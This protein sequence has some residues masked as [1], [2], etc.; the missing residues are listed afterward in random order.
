LKWLLNERAA[1]AGRVATLN[2]STGLLKEQV[3]CA[4]RRVDFLAG[5]VSDAEDRLRDADGSLHALDVVLETSF[6]T[7][8]QI[9]GGV[10][11]AWAGKY[12]QRGGL[13][14]HILS[15]LRKAAPGIVPTGL[16][17]KVAISHFGLQLT[18]DKE[19]VAF[20]RQ[21]RNILRGEPKLVEEL[22]K[23][24]LRG[25]VGWRWRAAPSLTELLGQDDWHEATD[26]LRPEVGG[27]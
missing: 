5:K 26:P 6:P 17:A 14:A 16:L 19:K 13:K 25:A 12:G 18:S 20:R 3:L 23:Q 11:R 22:G 27:Q 1:L 10:V 9:A 24:N 4:Q 7:V 8:S 21:V 15:V 2:H